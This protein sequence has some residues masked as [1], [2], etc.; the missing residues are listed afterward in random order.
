MTDE[1]KYALDNYINKSTANLQKWQHQY[2]LSLSKTK[3]M[4]NTLKE[5]RFEEFS[6]RTTKKLITITETL[7]EFRKLTRHVDDIVDSITCRAGSFLE[8]FEVAY[9]K[10]NKDDIEKLF[11][12]YEKF[13]KLMSNPA[14]IKA[15]EELKTITNVP[16]VW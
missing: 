12:T 16:N 1:V 2:L 15:L 13:N 9:G 11:V 5:L 3:P 4:T 8:A 14:I 10:Q 6:K 7:E